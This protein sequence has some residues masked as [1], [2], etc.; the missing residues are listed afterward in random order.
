MNVTVTRALGLDALYQVLD[1][2]VF[3][4]LVIVTGVLVL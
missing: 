3:R 1:N 2:K 4:I